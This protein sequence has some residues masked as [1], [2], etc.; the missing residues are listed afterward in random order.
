MNQDAQ[1][2]GPITVPLRDVEQ[3]LRHQRLRLQGENDPPAQLVRMSNLVIYCESQLSA[4]VILAQVPSIIAVHPARVLL[5]VADPNRTAPDLTAQVYV[6]GQPMSERRKSCS[7]L[8]VLTTSM[9]ERDRLPFAVRSLV[10]GELPSNLWWAVP[11]PPPLAGI[12]LDDL[13]EN[14]QQIIYDSVGWTDPVR[15]IAA[16]ARWLEDVEKVTPGGRWRVASDINW[17]RLKY[18]RRLVN[19]ALD[20]A[21]A[22]EARETISEIAIEHGPHSFVRV[23][24]LLCWISQRS[25]WEVETGKFRLGVETSWRFTSPGGSVRA[26]IIRQ[27]HEIAGL[28]RIRIVCKQEGKPTTLVLASE[29]DTRL[30]IRR[31]GDGEPR[32]VLIPPRS[33]EEL[34]GRQLSDRE[35][36]AAFRD[37]M[38][39]AGRLAQCVLE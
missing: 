15:G 36:D 7:E 33:P 5:L 9:D 37:S 35:R 19:Q 32:T 22:H 23:C 20:P 31:E 12:F 14:A 3:E 1:V 10:I 11:T 24:Q 34:I 8:V 17:R 4:D 28:R 30:A 13:G 18:W 27:D 29:A 39:V 38:V 2:V 26:R 6:K 25:G 16:T 21:T